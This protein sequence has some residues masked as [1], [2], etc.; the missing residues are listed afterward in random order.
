MRDCRSRAVRVNCNESASTV[1][2][3]GVPQ[4]SVLGPK[5]FLSTTPKT[6]AR[7]SASM[8]SVTICSPMTC[9]VYAMASQLKSHI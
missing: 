3:F 7:S 9:N 8:T 6:S 1:L 4:R 2:K 5:I